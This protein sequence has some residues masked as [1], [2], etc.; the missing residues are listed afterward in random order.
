MEIVLCLIAVITLIYL[1]F[2]YELNYWKRRNVPYAE[3]TIVVGN[4]GEVL[5][6]RKSAIEIYND[7]YEKFR[8]YKYCGFFQYRKPSLLIMDLDIIK[9]VLIKNFNNFHDVPIPIDEKQD[10]ILTKNPFFSKGNQWKMIRAQLTPQFTSGKIKGMFPL[11]QEIG[12]KLV[13]YLNTEVEATGKD[14]LNAKELAS[15]FTA[16][17]VAS[18]AFGI[19]GRS[20]VD[21]KATFMELGKNIF[22]PSIIDFILFSFLDI[23]PEMQ[24]IKVPQYI[25]TDTAKAFTDIILT[26]LKQREENNIKRGDFLDVVMELKKTTTAFDYNTD[27]MVAHALT[28][29]L[30]GFET[31]SIVIQYAC[32]ELGANPDVQSKL[33]KEIQRVLLENDGTFNDNILQEMKYLDMVLQETLR[34]YPPIA[35]MIRGCTETITIEPAQDGGKPLIID[36][37]SN[38]YIP[39][40]AIH[41]DPK[42]Y[43]DPDKFDPE[44]FDGKNKENGLKFAYLPFGE[45]PRMC[46]GRRFGITQVKMAIVSIVK[47]FELRVNKKTKVPLKLDPL[48]FFPVVKGGVWINFYGLKNE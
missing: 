34:M 12:G 4:F 5:L 35:A 18:C 11:L 44:R 38:I 23:F 7:I 41:R 47:N 20:F 16:D 31:S 2:K 28:F 46:L 39:V 27:Y 10:P 6:M 43:P 30:D 29:F 25:K 13:K 36:K 42:Y 17:C 26:N 8:G 15:K 24:K 3:G 14:G 32:Y 45:G 40:M 33:R 1:Y 19:D 22:K 9:D 48:E 37:G 21:P